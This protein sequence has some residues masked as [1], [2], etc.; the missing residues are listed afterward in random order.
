MSLPL[1][2][3]MSPV[4]LALPSLSAFSLNPIFNWYYQ[5][6]ATLEYYT[7]WFIY[8]SYCTWVIGPKYSEYDQQ[9]VADECLQA[10][11]EE[12]QRNWAFSG[13]IWFILC[14]IWYLLYN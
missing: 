10:V 2:S 8:A 9:L 3:I 6:M 12:I 14:G 5:T 4:L 13:E 7:F 11:Q 1:L